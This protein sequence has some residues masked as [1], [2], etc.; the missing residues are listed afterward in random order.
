[1]ALTTTT[2]CFAHGYA[3]GHNG[4]V[5]PMAAGLPRTCRQLHDYQVHANLPNGSLPASQASFGGLRKNSFTSW[6]ANLRAK[7]MSIWLH[8]RH[9]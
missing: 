2:G 9:G 1:M 4:A 6:N 3:P 5:R 7:A 8:L